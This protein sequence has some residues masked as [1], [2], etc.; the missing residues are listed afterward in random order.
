MNQYL[1]LWQSFHLPVRLGLAL[2]V[3][4]TL[5]SGRLEALAQNRPGSWQFW[6]SI[7]RS[8]PPVPP[9]EGGGR[10][11][12]CLIAPTVSPDG[13]AQVWN[14]QPTF[15]W[16]GAVGKLE[17]KQA[18]QETIIWEQSAGAADFA[19]YEGAPLAPDTTYRWL[20]YLPSADEPAFEVPFTV[21]P[22]EEKAAI[23]QDLQQLDA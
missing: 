22:T 7:F 13:M 1:S 23:A 2:L 6:G 4:L 11:D 3:G 8:E 17:L 21:L 12:V 18:G 9:T 15:V 16:R 20:V 19:T 14:S 5:T 10:G